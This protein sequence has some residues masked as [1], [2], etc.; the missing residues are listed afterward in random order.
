M[1]NV[2]EIIHL[3]IVVSDQ[4]LKS[5]EGCGACSEPGVN[6]VTFTWDTSIDHDLHET[7]PK[8]DHYRDLDPELELDIPN[9]PM[10]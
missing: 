9:C 6:N 5:D 7:E 10:R 1:C 2:L 4:I 8:D 3:G